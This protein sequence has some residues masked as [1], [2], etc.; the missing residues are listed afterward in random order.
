[1][2][3][4][5]EGLDPYIGPDARRVTLLTR[6]G[7]LDVLHLACH[8]EFDSTDPLLSRLYLA[9]GPVYGYEISALAV[10]GRMV[11]LSPCETRVQARYPGD[12]LYG[13]VRAFV[14]GDTAGVVSS[15]WAVPDESSE[16]FMTEFYRSWRTG[17]ST[18]V[19]TLRAAQ[20][21]LLSSAAYQHPRFWAPYLLIGA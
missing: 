13:L 14:A 5:I 2:A 21:H 17:D 11:V 1:V 10:A 8:G 9:D 19:E 4:A 7:A 20:L 18:P 12:E 3:F 6:S 16:L 15:L